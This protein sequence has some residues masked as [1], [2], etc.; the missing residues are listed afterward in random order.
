LC[1]SSQRVKTWALIVGLIAVA[2]TLVHKMIAV[3]NN[4]MIELQSGFGKLHPHLTLSAS[5][6]ALSPRQQPWAAYFG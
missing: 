4:W 6:K 2:A 5:T 3:V 1:S